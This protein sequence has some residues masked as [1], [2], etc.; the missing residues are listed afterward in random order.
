MMITS[1]YYCKVFFSSDHC[2]GGVSISQ[3]WD[4]ELFRFPALGSGEANASAV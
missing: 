3:W 1:M 4:L 2:L